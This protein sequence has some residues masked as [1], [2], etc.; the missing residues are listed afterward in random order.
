MSR[1]KAGQMKKVIRQGVHRPREK[2]MKLAKKLLRI[3]EAL[4]LSQNGL[5]EE[6]GLDEVIKQRNVSA[7]ERGYREPNLLTLIKYAK[8]ANVCLD[9]LINDEYDLPVDLPPKRTYHPH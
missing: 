6:L 8:A 9:V 2:P 4:E 7:W 1:A 3:R 5:I